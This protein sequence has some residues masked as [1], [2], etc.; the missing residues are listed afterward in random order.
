M[1]DD[2]A[3][4]LVQPFFKQYGVPLLLAGISLFCIVATLVLLVKT[5][6]TSQPIRFSGDLDSASTSSQLIIVDIEG[7]VGKPGVYRLQE[8]SRIDDLLQ[9]SG[10]LTD[11]ADSDWVA[12]SLNR[13][14][15]LSD[16]AKLF[17]PNKGAQ[18]TV[19]SAQAMTA[20]AVGGGQQEIISINSASAKELDTLPG[21]G[22]VTAK[23]IMDNRPYLRLEEL[24][25]KKV[26]TGSVFE[27]IKS[28]ITL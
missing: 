8:G 4:S 12:R 6:Q 14:S 26:L 23:K 15:I 1:G 22:E 17:I 7:A 28:Q 10:G 24:V 25:E 16:G 21:I 11:E 18:P 2:D 13:A 3:E 9:E 5:T 19:N 20:G 27:K